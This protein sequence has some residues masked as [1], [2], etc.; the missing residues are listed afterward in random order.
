MFT[1]TNE[2]LA[3]IVDYLQA[4]NIVVLHE[5]EGPGATAVVLYLEVPGVGLRELTV[6]YDFLRTATP[7]QIGQHMK[8]EDYVSQLQDKNAHI[9]RVLG[10]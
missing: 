2:A 9:S 5:H 10:T 7:Q 1:S 4:N 6:N 3:P 8:D